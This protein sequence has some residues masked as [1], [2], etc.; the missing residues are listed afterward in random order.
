MNT[1]GQNPSDHPQAT[2]DDLLLAEALAQTCQ[3]YRD[4]FAR[5]K[6]EPKADETRAHAGRMLEVIRSD[7]RLSLFADWP[8]F[9]ELAVR[10]VASGQ[11]KDVS[12][13]SA[14]EVMA[15]LDAPH[16]QL[17]GN[18]L[19]I[20]KRN[21]D[22]SPRYVRDPLQAL[23]DDPRAWE[24]NIGKFMKAAVDHLH[25]AK[26]LDVDIPNTAAT[27]ELK[28]FDVLSALQRARYRAAG[29]PSWYGAGDPKAQDKMLRDTFESELTARATAGA[30]AVAGSEMAGCGPS[31]CAVSRTP[32]VPVLPQERGW[33]RKT[34]PC[35]SMDYLRY[36]AYTYTIGENGHLFQAGELFADRWAQATNWCWPEESAEQTEGS[37]AKCQ[38]FDD[39]IYCLRRRNA[40]TDTAYAMRAEIYQEQLENPA[41]QQ[42]WS[43]FVSQVQGYLSAPCTGATR[44]PSY[45]C[46]GVYTAA[47][48]LRRTAAAQL[49]GLARMQIKELAGFLQRVLRLFTNPRVIGLIDPAAAGSQPP[50]G[51]ASYIGKGS[52]DQTAVVAAVTQQLLGAQASGVYQAWDRA[53]LLDQVLAWVQCGHAWSPGQGCED[54]VEFVTMLGAVSALVSGAGRAS[55]VPPASLT[56]ATA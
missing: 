17:I 14:D 13:V 9:V 21:A 23:W 40:R 33:A 54:D 30:A 49:T 6:A 34:D 38:S 43:N 47:E 55:S 10:Q 2:T 45:R 26:R 24:G 46:L 39:L 15:A 1:A 20:L 32:L 28:P 25:V 52:A 41:V 48:A 56:T 22:P 31:V 12:E 5:I 50:S 42:A 7:A 19:E 37:A 4:E 3:A 11:K 36:L 16:G 44:I 51:T 53:M 29:E 35:N 8:E 27:R 18:L